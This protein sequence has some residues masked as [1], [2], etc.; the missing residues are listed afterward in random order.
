LRRVKFANPTRHVT[1]NSSPTRQSEQQKASG[2]FRSLLIA[3]CLHYPLSVSSLGGSL[4]SRK[5]IAQSI[6]SFGLKFT[7][8]ASL[9][10]EFVNCQQL[11][12][13][14]KLF[15]VASSQEA[16]GTSGREGKRRRRR[17]KANRK[18]HIRA[19]RPIVLH[20]FMA[21]LHSRKALFF[22]LTL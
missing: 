17:E 6:A 15:S 18:T 10:I 11:Q 2:R 19:P 1:L 3:E 14:L 22:L 4:S 16:C 20:V 5:K 9:S 7:W 21:L 13:L 8:W 12:L